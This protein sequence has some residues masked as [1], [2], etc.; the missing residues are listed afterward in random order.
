M[1]GDLVILSLYNII[2]RQ[3]CGMPDMFV[4]L[5]T[6][7]ASARRQLLCVDDRSDMG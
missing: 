4:S 2:S 1:A 6:I 5:Y 3:L 7:N